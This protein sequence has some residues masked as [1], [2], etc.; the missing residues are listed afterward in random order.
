MTDAANNAAAEARAAVAD[1]DPP[2]IVDWALSQH[3]ATCAIAFSGAEDVVLIDMAKESGHE[4][5]VFTL[6]TGRLHPETY[7]FLDT[8]RRHYDVTID[9][10][11]PESGAVGALVRTK[12]LFSFYEDGHQECCQ[13]RK[14]KP[15]QRILEPYHAWMTGQR[16][17]QSPETRSQLQLV[18]SAAPPPGRSGP[19]LKFNPLAN[20]SSG[21]VWDYIHTHNV[22]YNPLHARGFRSIGCAP[23]TRAVLPE[24]HE[25]DGRWW[26][27]RADHKECGLHR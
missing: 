18:E 9:V 16:S 6:D 24:Q 10:A 8:V 27:E 7:Q 19:S 21:Q 17:D 23:C 26:W 15:L 1:R 12:G 2:A 13:I 20:W 25:R 4:F 22:P 3:G 5:S 14:V 11:F